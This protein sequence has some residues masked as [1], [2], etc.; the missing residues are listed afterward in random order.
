[1]RADPRSDVF[2]LGC[3]C[4]ELLTGR[5]PFEAESMH[6]VLY[7]VMQEEPVP[8]RELL[9]G[10]PEVL[11]QFLEKALAKTPDERF[12]NAGEMRNAL[13]RVREA[14]ASGRGGDSLPELRRARARPEPPPDE[15]RTGIDGR[16]PGRARSV[17]RMLVAAAALALLVAGVWALRARPPAAAVRTAEVAGLARAVVKA[18]T[19][20]ARRRLDAGEFGDAVRQADRALEIDPSYRAARQVRDEASAVLARIARASAALRAARGDPEALAAAAFELMAIDPARPEAA[21]AAL[22]AGPAFRPLVEEARRRMR[23][24][25]LASSAAG[26]DGDPAFAQGIAMAEQGD[27]AARAGQAPAAARQYLAARLQFD[28]ARRLA[29]ER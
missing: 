12:E 20:L 25:R 7:K 10:T 24:A 23:D 4:Y 29:T 28:R 16:A 14:I 5:K 26:A 9:P 1:M 19:E 27:E 2:A 21:N 15:G 13:R 3:V 22:R 8:A 17:R 6:A 18:R 11:Q